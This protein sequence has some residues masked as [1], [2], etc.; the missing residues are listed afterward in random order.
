[1]KK[2]LLT[3]FFLTLIYTAQSQE[4]QLLQHQAL[5][6]QIPLG[7]DQVEFVVV[8]TVLTQK[9][10]V[11]LWCQGSLPV[12]LFCEIDP[13]G[14]FFFGGGITNF[15]YKKIRERYH[16]VIISM[17]KT[18]VMGSKNHLNARYQY[19]P[20]SSQPYTFAPEYV[21]SD[22]LENYVKR[23]NAVLK[24][25]WS[26]KWVEHQRLVVAGH[27]QGSKV[28]A[29]L[30]RTNKHITHLGLF[31]ANPLGRVDQ[32]VREARLEAQT[33]KISWEKADSIM[34]DHYAY[35]KM[36]QNPDSVKTD[37]SL[38]AWAS[39][40]E[41][42]YDDWLQLSIPIYLAYGTEDRTSDL[43]DI[44][45]FFFAQEKKNNLTLKRYLRLEHN[46]FEVDAQGRVNYEKGHWVEAMN[47]FLAW[48]K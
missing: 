23:G 41:P 9:K 10:P 3:L 11:F 13:Q 16:L 14:Y 15:D 20:D 17:P 8:D 30:A 2:H 26:K 29:K 40:S 4:G 38:K 48:I 27:S 1:M 28:A 34:N 25:L 35:F 36:A 47:A 31:S 5:L 46:F 22:Y 44:V 39:F 21:E 33:G 37:P 43:C 24:F 19:I 18:P 12:P 6:F 45:P 42:M 7:S 32:L